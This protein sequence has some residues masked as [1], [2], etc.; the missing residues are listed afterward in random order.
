MSGPKFVIRLD[1][2][3][4]TLRWASMDKAAALFAELGIRPLIGVVPDNRDEHLII[5]PPRPNFWELVRAWVNAGWVVAQHGYQHRY[6]NRSP[7]VLRIGSRSEFAGLPFEE[8]HRK[9]SLGHRLLEE[10]GIDADT[11]MAPSHSFDAATLAAMR[12][13]GMKYVTDGFGLFPYEAD[14]LTFVPQLFASPWHFGVG[15]YTV[16]LHVND[17][18][19]A[20]LARLARFC[21]S[22][23]Q[24][25]I[26]FREA[27]AIR[28]PRVLTGWTGWTLAHGIRGARHLRA[29]VKISLS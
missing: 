18:D 5:D 17:M 1:D 22:R 26:D 13:V 10:R 19:E 2:V 27:S 21:H 28:G 20:G 16:C 15:I 9:L 29:R 14:S 25:I 24:D 23:R 3:C 11:F 4:P 7:G 12:A 8:Q 6:V